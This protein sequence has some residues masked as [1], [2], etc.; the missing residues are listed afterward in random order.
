MDALVVRTYLYFIRYILSHTHDRQYLFAPLD[1]TVN[2]ELLVLRE[3]IAI[4]NYKDRLDT[5]L[6]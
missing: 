3:K 5:P 4:T 6:Q 1:S 2:A